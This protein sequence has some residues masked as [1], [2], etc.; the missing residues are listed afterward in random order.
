MIDWSISKSENPDGERTK[1][2]R[3]AMPVLTSR[4]S[5]RN[6]YRCAARRRKS[7]MRLSTHAVKKTMAVHVQ[8]GIA[9]MMEDAALSRFS[10]QTV[11]APRTMTRIVLATASRVIHGVPVQTTAVDCVV[12]VG[13]GE[14]SA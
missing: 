1:D 12:V 14:T 9:R 8:T 5:L 4:L 3:L 11:I 6:V 2:W 7:G 13:N 10:S